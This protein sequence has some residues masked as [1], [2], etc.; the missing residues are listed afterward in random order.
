MNA[1]G[2]PPYRQID[3]RDLSTKQSRLYTDWKFLMRELEIHYQQQSG[4]SIKS[5]KSPEEVASS[6]ETSVSCLD[7]IKTATA[8]KRQRRFSQL[9]V[10]TVVKLLR[11]SKGP[12]F[13][14]PFAKRKRAKSN[15]NSEMEA[16]RK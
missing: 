8:T 13:T 10:L 3:R 5:I 15:A 6:F 9:T 7:S 4:K 1:K 12:S 2:Y 11:Q 14:R 16:Q